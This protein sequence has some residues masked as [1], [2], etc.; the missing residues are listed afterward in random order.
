[1]R[2]YF[3]LKKVLF[4]NFGEVFH[5]AFSDL[6]SQEKLCSIH[7]PVTYHVKNKETTSVLT[8]NL[9]TKLF[10]SITEKMET[11]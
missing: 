3:S 7:L 1:M 2:D 8:V 9:F 6:L 5:V 11:D 10:E 4:C